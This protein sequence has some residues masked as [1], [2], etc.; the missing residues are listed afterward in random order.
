MRNFSRRHASIACFRLLLPS[1]WSV[2]GMQAGG[3]A[4]AASDS[5]HRAHDHEFFWRSLCQFLQ[6]LAHYLINR[7]RAT[8]PNRRLRRRRRPQVRQLRAHN[9][10][11]PRKSSLKRR[12]KRAQRT[13]IIMAVAATP[14]RRT[15]RKVPPLRPRRRTSSTKQHSHTMT[16][17]L[18]P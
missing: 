4:T 2:S 6:L 9:R 5:L 18:R 12:S 10:Q 14:I 3:A 1:R 17:P 11:R 7:S 16:L 8:R 15:V 13:V